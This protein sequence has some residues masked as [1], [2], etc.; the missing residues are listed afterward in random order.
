MVTMP[1]QEVKRR[2]MS[3]LD[4][5]LASGPVYVIRNNTPRYVV[6]FADTFREMEDALA[7]ARIAASEA[8]IKNGRV[9]RGTADELM[10][11]LMGA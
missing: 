8:D 3:V 5:S 4:N 9:T 11:E 10:A 7:D 1:I 6:M 2:G